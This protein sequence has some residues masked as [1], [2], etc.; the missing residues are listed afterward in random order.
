MSNLTKSE[1]T[2]QNTTLVP[3]TAGS[4]STPKVQAADLNAMIG[5][6]I[7]S[8][9]TAAKVDV[10]A[11]YVDNPSG[12]TISVENATANT[13]LALNFTYQAIA[14]DNGSIFRIVCKSLGVNSTIAI[15]FTSTLVAFSDHVSGNV[16]GSVF[17]I[18]SEGTYE[19]LV[20]NLQFLLVSKV[21]P[22]PEVLVS[23]G[24]ALKFDQ[25]RV[26]N[27]SAPAASFSYDV[28]GL[29][30]GVTIKAYILAGTEP[31]LPAGS[32]LQS[33]SSAFQV[34]V[35]NIYTITAIDE[36]TF[37]IIR[38]YQSQG[39]DVQSPTL[40]TITVEDAEP[41][42]V[43]KTY[44]EALDP[45]S[46]PDV[47]D[48][49]YRV[50][51]VV[52]A[53]TNVAVVGSTVELTVPSVSNGEVL[54]IDYTPDANP[55]QDLAGNDAAAL[56]GQSITN[57]VGGGGLNFVDAT[58]N[59]TTGADLANKPT[60]S[61]GLNEGVRINNVIGQGDRFAFDVAEVVAGAAESSSA[62][63]IGL[64][65]STQIGQA[66]P[67]NDTI[68]GLRFTATVLK[69]YDNG[70]DVGNVPGGYNLGDR[71]SL[72]WDGS[73]NLQVEEW[74]GSSWVN[75]NQIK[76]G[77]SGTKVICFQPV[78][79]GSAIANCVIE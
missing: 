58:A 25:P 68:D 6:L 79:V 4:G 19:F 13:P 12:K 40:Q 77:M 76:T 69:K 46:V 54:D 15:T 30:P 62:M 8:M 45:G 24:T 59:V 23:T 44:D 31:P 26:Y 73:D 27:K 63:R 3:P 43:V 39:G 2:S 60:G 9:K 75:R 22:V 32:S 74:N 20:D 10:S 11:D 55:I 38:S 48:F 72:Y 67:E 29:V 56:S 34:G 49:V 78:K 71:L 36:N 52:T 53:V 37:E 65:D 70:S 42:K 28:T 18:R 17:T 47:G 35:P 5:H 1:L 61:D 14:G 66:N 57:N 64:V 33:I 16:S 21:T 7:D 50:D 41:T 51:T